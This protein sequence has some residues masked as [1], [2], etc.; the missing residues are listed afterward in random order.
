MLSS[1]KLEL[2]WVSKQTQ[3]VYIG[4][5]T[6]VQEVTSQ[7]QEVMSQ[8]QEVMSQVMW[9]YHNLPSH[10]T[11]HQ[12]VK[13]ILPFFTHHNT[14]PPKCKYVLILKS[15]WWVLKE[16]IYL[17]SSNSWEKNHNNNNIW[18]FP[19]VD[20]IPKYVIAVTIHIYNQN[21]K[22]KHFII[23]NITLHTHPKILSN[24]KIKLPLFWSDTPA[25][26]ALLTK[27]KS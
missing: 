11:W 12:K 14:L 3:R 19:T 25:S 17:V 10:G 13:F 2:L 22:F 27:L 16:G 18:T 24:T 4:F 23:N 15:I 9:L 7:I 5:G 26:R 20:L 8:V 1:V 21:E 6:H